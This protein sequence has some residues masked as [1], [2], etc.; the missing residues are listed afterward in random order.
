MGAR[1]GPHGSGS[2]DK[3]LRCDLVSRNSHQKSSLEFEPQ[4]IPITISLN[5]NPISGFNFVV[6][7]QDFQ[8]FRLRLEPTIISAVSF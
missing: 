4:F 2:C 1:I 6:L 5:L 8:Q 3:R 7:H